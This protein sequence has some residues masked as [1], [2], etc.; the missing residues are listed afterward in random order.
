MNN[1]ILQT[2]LDLLVEG[3]SVIPIQPRSKIP[4]LKSWKPYQ[5]RL[6]TEAEVREWFS[7]GDKNMAVVCGAV[8]GNLTILDFDQV[9]AARAWA[10]KYRSLVSASPIVKPSRGWHVWIRTDRSVPCSRGDGI[11]V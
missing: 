11:D 10:E 5:E 6:P 1:E 2:A 9:K 3:I 8:S 7:N 4:A